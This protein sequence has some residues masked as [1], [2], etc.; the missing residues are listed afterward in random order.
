MKDRSSSKD[1]VYLSMD[2]KAFTRSVGARTVA[3]GGGCVSALVASL[4]SALTCM[5]SLLSY[6]NRK[7]EKNDEAVKDIVPTLYNTYNQLL[8]YIDQDAVAFNSYIVSIY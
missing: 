7:Y 8:Y 5:T 6:G 4:G 1:G 3:P 2:L